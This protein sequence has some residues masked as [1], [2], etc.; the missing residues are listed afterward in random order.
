MKKDNVMK[1]HLTTSVI[2]LIIIFTSII[3]SSLSWPS[4]PDNIGVHFAGDGSFD[5]FVDKNDLIFILY[6]YIV[7]LIVMILSG[8]L[9]YALNRVKVGNKQDEKQEI[10]IKT[11]I[12]I[13]VDVFFKM[14]W[15]YFLAVVWPSCVIKQQYLNTEVPI[16]LFNVYV[17]SLVILI[18][19]IF[20]VKHEKKKENNKKKRRKRNR[21]KTL[22]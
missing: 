5:V 1:I 10:K 3:K 18:L 6:P 17:F 7:S 11:A 20:V 2:A 15:I 16:L 22:L 14:I 12:A 4:L 8:I 19:Y 9:I 21:R 13:Q